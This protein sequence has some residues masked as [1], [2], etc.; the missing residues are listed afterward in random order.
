MESMEDFPVGRTFAL[1]S[2]RLGAAYVKEIAK[3][4]GLP[5][6]AAGDEL[7][8]LIEGH[9]SEEGREPPNVQ[10][11]I[12]EKT[13][14][15]KGKAY[16]CLYLADDSGVFKEIRVC[17]DECVDEYNDE[18]HD[19]EHEQSEHNDRIS[20]E[21]ENGSSGEVAVVALRQRLRVVETEY[22]AVVQ[23]KEREIEQLRQQI[24]TV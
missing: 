22:E 19:E 15:E 18:E 8:Q 2:R 23:E 13:R 14:Q 16:W 3:G 17:N 5:T 9:L 6:K 12:E 7:R 4:M 11:I 1:N 21:E 10:V 24:E 20:S